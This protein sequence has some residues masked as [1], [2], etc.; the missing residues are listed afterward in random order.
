MP[1]TTRQQLYGFEF[2]EVKKLDTG[3]PITVQALEDGDIDVGAALHRQ[4]RDPEGRGAAQDDKGLQPA[5][6]PVFLVARTRRRRRR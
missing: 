3:G 6:N 4:Q 1:R 5:D 2:T